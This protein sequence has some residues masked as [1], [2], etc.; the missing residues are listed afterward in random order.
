[1][2]INERLMWKKAKWQEMRTLTSLANN[3]E[4]KK[5]I[6]VPHSAASSILI[7]IMKGL[8]INMVNRLEV[9]SSKAG[10]D[11]PMTVN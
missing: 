11:S 6:G 5:R 7:K 10:W 2:S 9:I 4:V 8:N 3:L 1:M